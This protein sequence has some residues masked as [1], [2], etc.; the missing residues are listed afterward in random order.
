M[1]DIVPDEGLDLLLGI[2]PK[3]GSNLANTYLMLFTSQTASTVPGSTA[4]LATSTG[5]TEAG[6]TSYARVA[7]AAADWGSAGAATIWTVTARKVTAA[8]KSFPGA[9][10]PYS[11]A[12]NGFGLANQLATGAGSIGIYYSNFDD[13]TAI[14]SLGTGDVIKVTPTFGFGG[15]T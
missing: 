6:F 3:N 15:Q 10:A 2:F 5:V 7:V 11:T 1:A 9:G 8:Q 13:T 4:V 12:I 14:P